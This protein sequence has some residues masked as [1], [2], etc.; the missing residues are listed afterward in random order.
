MGIHQATDFY[1]SVFKV[2]PFLPALLKKVFSLVKRE[3]SLKKKKKRFSGYEVGT[4]EISLQPYISRKINECPDK[5]RTKKQI[6]GF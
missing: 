2:S 5:L 4:N 3:L 6:Q 1:A